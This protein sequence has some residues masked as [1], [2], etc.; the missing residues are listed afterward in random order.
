M[1]EDAFGPLAGLKVVDIAT[2]I[3][4]PLAGSLLAD[5][6]ADVWKF[7]MPGVGDGLRAFP[8][9]KD[10]KPLWWKVTNRGKRFATLDLRQKEG[11]DL[12][13]RILVDSDVLIE[14]F[15]PGTLDKWGLD[16]E[17]LWA[18]NP[19]LVILRV[20]AFGQTGPRASQGGFA[21]IFEAMGGLTHITGQSDGPPIHPGYPLADA[22]GGLFG[23]FSILAALRGVDKQ[24]IQG[25]EIDLSL[26]EATF[27]VL[28]N[29]AIEYDQLGSVRSRMG[30]HNQYT[31]PSNVYQTADGHFVTLTSSTDSTFKANMAAIGQAALA[32]EA[33]F[34]TNTLR[35]ANLDELD[36]HFSAYFRQHALEDVL[37]SFRAQKGAI[38]PIYTIEQIFNDAQFQARDALPEV[39]DEDFGQVRMQGVVPKMRNAPGKIRWTAGA[40]GADNDEMYRDILG[41]DNEQLARLRADGVV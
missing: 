35:M 17:T 30:N 39:P 24:R 19:K 33:R 40:V 20:S 31:A 27:R 21:R 34:K 16:K 12:L 41:L 7:E 8:P 9:F 13:K 25:E 2:I 11:S 32:G 5:F 15:R 23:A 3:A 26:T 18:I 38:A 10:D 1:S 28:E 4:G 36:R 22:V 14:N 29:I 6:G 37:A